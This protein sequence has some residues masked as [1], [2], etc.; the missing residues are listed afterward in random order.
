VFILYLIGKCREDVNYKDQNDE[1]ACHY[2][3]KRLR[4]DVI[5]ILF[6]HNANVNAENVDG[7]T[8]LH[9]AADIYNE[10][11]HQTTKMDYDYDDVVN[12]IDT[13]LECGADRNVAN[14]QGYFPASWGRISNC[15][16][17]AQYIEN[18]DV[19]AKDGNGN[20][21]LHKACLA[22]ETRVVEALLTCGAR[23]E[24]LNRGGLTPID[25][26]NMLGY[27]SIVACL[28]SSQGISEEKT[29]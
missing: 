16:K 23:A 3:V 10:Y 13:L 18:W 25:Y 9:L 5:K 28:K 14:H 17:I 27:Q 1:T 6:K 26:A 11:E 19:N 8:S 2:A 29:I 24:E 15:E 4:S 12:V 7:N 21:R 22:N 20:T